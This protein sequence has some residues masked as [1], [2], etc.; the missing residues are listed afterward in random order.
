MDTPE[1]VV[2]L[3]P[4][5]FVEVYEGSSEV[6][7]GGNNLYFPFASQQEWQFA[8]WLLCSRLSLIAIDSLLVLDIQ[9]RACAEVLPSG[10]AWLCKELEPK[11]PTK[12]PDCLFYRQLLKCLQSLLSHPLL[13]PHI[14][15]VPQRV[16]MSAARVC[17]I[18]DEWLSGDR[19]WEIQDTLPHGA[20]VLGVV[21]SSDKTNIS[22][23]TGNHVAHP[24]LISLANIDTSI[25]SKMSLHRY[26]LLALLPIPKFVHK[27]THICGLLQDQLIHQALN[28]VL[29]P[30]KTA[31]T[32]GIMMTIQHACTEQDP[33]DYKNF[34]KVIRALCLNS[35]IEP[36]W[37]GWPLSEPSDFITPEP[38]HH[39]HRFSWDHD[40]W[41]YCMFEDGV[42]KLK[43]VTGCNHCA[44]QHYI[45]GI[46]AGSIP[47]HF[48]TAIHLLMDFQ[49]LAQVPMFMD[50]SLTEVV[51]ALQDFYD[52]KDTIMA[53]RAQKDS[54]DIPKVELLQSIVPSI[55]LSGAVMQ[56]PT[57]P[58]EHAHVQEIKVPAQAGN[59]WDYYNQIA[60][61]LDHAEKC[62]CFDI[63][64]YMESKW[65]E[66]YLQVDKIEGN[67]TE[68]DKE[69]E[70]D[71]EE[72]PTDHL[73]ATW[74]PINYFMIMDALMCGCI[75]NAP[76]PYHT[77][78]TATTAF[79]LSTKP[80]LR[81]SV[82]EAAVMFN[83]PDLHA[84]ISEY[85]HCLQSRMPHHVSWV[86]SQQDHQLPFNH[87]QI[88]CKVHTPDTPQTLHAF[89]P[90][91]VN[92]HGLYDTTIINTDPDSN[93]LQQG[94]EGHSVVQLHMIFHPLHSELLAT[95]VQC[96]DIVTQQGNTNNRNAGTGMSRIGDVLLITL[97]HSPAHLIPHF[98]K[99]LSSDFWLNKYW[100]K[101][102]YYALSSL[103][104]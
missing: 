59:N 19:A 25:C 52:N 81:L 47:Q 24:V 2:P 66:E 31:A 55:C 23:M 101:E 16:W 46:I 21:L 7:P 71:E 54:W 27:T 64:T 53:A 39:F 104:C 17:H 75:P 79:H 28:Q 87:L 1:E 58:T 77:F 83:L 5:K 26:L 67:K 9:L 10:P 12:H 82:D 8:S 51:S 43:Q 97:I 32:V 30:L 85:L 91:T 14:S 41:W 88:W 99:E 70:L 33:F 6:F 34:I 69:H 98:G 61:H 37:R 49:Y 4:G 78:S 50:D 68:Q 94:L 36:I 15:F 42:S 72:F 96:F 100:S 20:T 92:L 38:L 29:T 57:D 13:A 93:W 44:I 56:W 35:V 86:R 40:T 60:C 62:L 95:Y 84:A 74:S 11:S 76:R 3:V 63:A 103:S 80:S 90:S 18:Y 45:T 22:V 65:G 102:F 89:S 48:L 73:A